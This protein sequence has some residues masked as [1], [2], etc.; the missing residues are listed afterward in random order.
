MLF[1]ASPRSSASRRASAPL[2]ARTR[3][4]LLQVAIRHK[5]AAPPSARRTARATRPRR[6]RRRAAA[7]AVVL[8][9]EA[10]LAPSAPRTHS[11]SA[12]TAMPTPTSRRHAP[13]LLPRPLPRASASSPSLAPA[14]RRAP[15]RRLP[16]G[17]GSARHAAALAS[18][19]SHC[20]PI[21]VCAQRTDTQFTIRTSVPVCD[22]R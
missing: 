16:S 9:P 15:K 13:R 21:P 20:L 11:A 17:S 18:L 3:W 6:P 22:E 12:R 7:A 4:P 14:V 2:R 1:D 5:T 10:L 19:L 8:A